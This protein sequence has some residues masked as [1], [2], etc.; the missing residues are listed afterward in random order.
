M[1][2]LLPLVIVGLVCLILGIGGT[3]VFV[4]LTGGS[5]IAL[6]GAQVR[7][8]PKPAPKKLFF[9]TLTDMTVSIA[10]QAGV[11]ASS[12]VNFSTHNHAAVVTFS[13]IEPIIKAALIT[14]VMNET[15]DSLQYQKARAELTQGFLTIVNNLMQQ[16]GGSAE[17]TPFTAAY[18]TNLLT[19]D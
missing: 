14:R 2:K 1:K 19:Q 13:E 11:Q 17:S 8:S 16:D 4:K 10:P 6:A 9:A 18:I 12:F 3:L 5:D 7:T 15:T